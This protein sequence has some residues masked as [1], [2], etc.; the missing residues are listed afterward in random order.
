MKHTENLKLYKVASAK[1]TYN[2]LFI[3]KA[4]L[5]DERKLLGERGKGTWSGSFRDWG[6]RAINSINPFIDATSKE[7]YENTG[8]RTAEYI[9]NHNDLLTGARPSKSL[10]NVAEIIDRI[11]R[12]AYEYNNVGLGGRSTEAITRDI[13]AAQTQL[14]TILNSPNARFSQG[15]L[16]IFK[17]ALP[18]LEQRFLNDTGLSLNLPELQGDTGTQAQALSKIVAQV[19]QANATSGMSAQTAAEELKRINE[20][21]SLS[22]E[23]KQQMSSE[24]INKRNEAI[25]NTELN[26]LSALQQ[27]GNLSK[28]EVTKFRNKLKQ[29]QEDINIAETPALLK[30][31]YALSSA[32]K[33]K[34]PELLAYTLNN[35]D[36]KS[37]I[38]NPNNPYAALAARDFLRSLNLSQEDREQLYQLSPE[39]RNRMQFQDAYKTREGHKAWERASAKNNYYGRDVR[40]DANKR[41][42]DIYAPGEEYGSVKGNGK[43]SFTAT[44]TKDA[45]KRIMNE[46]SVEAKRYAMLKELQNAESLEHYR[47]NLNEIHDHVADHY[48]N[49][50]GAKKGLDFS[51]PISNEAYDKS[52]ANRRKYIGSPSPDLLS[53]SPSSNSFK[54]R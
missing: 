39:L 12:L 22:A 32:T 42:V 27:T 20:D 41:K 5:W 6:R 30:R 10:Q 19:N 44:F 47:G 52:L 26:R 3:K 28:D 18:M 15:E 9:L 46:K 40:W 16:E 48:S 11:E 38:A 43:P 34:D 8:S 49:S 17:N 24:I 29:R 1:D 4:D 14:Y 54:Y 33:Q 45:W 13:R 25:L 7:D 23:Q 50:L 51:S 36:V 21:S 2:Q 53:S 31:L 37:A 35:S